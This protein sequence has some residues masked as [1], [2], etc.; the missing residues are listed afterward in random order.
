MPSSADPLPGLLP[1][2]LFIAEPTPSLRVWFHAPPHGASGT[3][4]LHRL[5][6]TLR[7]TADSVKKAC[8]GLTARSVFDRQ[9]MPVARPWFKED[10][11]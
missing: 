7:Q 3:G 5:V 6:R 1:A 8:A 2:V 11:T 9:N 10:G 4:S